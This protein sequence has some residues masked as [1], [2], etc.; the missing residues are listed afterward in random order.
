MAKTMVIEMTNMG[1]VRF[2]RS[3]SKVPKASVETLEPEAEVMTEVGAI[4][5][6][7]MQLKHMLWLRFLM[8]L[9]QV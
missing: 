5:A 6:I 9:L 2:N 8:R 3:S 7:F 1:I 4:K